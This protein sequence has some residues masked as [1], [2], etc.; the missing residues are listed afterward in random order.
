MFSR[1]ERI[2]GNI[3]AAWMAG[4]FLSGAVYAYTLGQLAR[5]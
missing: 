1:K 2:L 3:F 5:Q 4:K